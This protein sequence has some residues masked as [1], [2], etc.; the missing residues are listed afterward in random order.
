VFIWEKSLKIF[1]LRT[2]EPEELR[3]IWKLPDKVVKIMAPK[4]GWGLSKECHFY[5]L[6]LYRKNLKNL[7]KNHGARKVQIYMAAS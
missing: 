6:F 4:L 5:L 3:F 2:I 1:F 7:I